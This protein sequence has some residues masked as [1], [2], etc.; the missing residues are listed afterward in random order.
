MSKF[1]YLKND[2]HVDRERD[3]TT[4]TDSQLT[5]NWIRNLVMSNQQGFNQEKRRIWKII[6]D[7]LEN[8]MLADSDYFE[9]NRVEHGFLM[10]CCAQAVIDAKYS[11]SASVA[12]EAVINAVDQIPT[13]APV[14]PE[15]PSTPPA[16]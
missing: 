5:L 6:S 7:K 4:P 16:E 15:V 10:I 12:E 2:F 3:K 14:E 8:A 13:A 1:I 11:D 9:V